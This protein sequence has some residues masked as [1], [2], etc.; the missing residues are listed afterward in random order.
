[1]KRTLFLFSAML[2]SS[3]SFAQAPGAFK[4]QAVVRD[5]SG[6]LIAEQVIGLQI[7]ILKGSTDGSSVYTETHSVTTNT[8]GLVNLQIGNG[9]TTDD[10]ST[11]NWGEDDYFIQVSL[12]TT[13]GTC[14]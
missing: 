12:D 3:L 2:I 11:I 14:I 1:M 8:L 4:Y 10:F 13:G 6:N 5:N 9:T 7:D